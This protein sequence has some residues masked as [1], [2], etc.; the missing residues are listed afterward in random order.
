[1]LKSIKN[2]SICAAVFII[3]C[4][5]LLFWVMIKSQSILVTIQ[6]VTEP[7]ETS[8]SLRG[9]MHADVWYNAYDIVDSGAWRYDAEEGTYSSKNDEIL[10]LKVPVCSQFALVFNAGPNEGVVQIKVGNNVYLCDLYQETE[11]EYGYQ[12][13]LPGMEDQFITINII[14]ALICVMI[15][16]VCICITAIYEKNKDKV[17]L[18][19]VEIAYIVA[20]IPI[21]ALLLYF[22]SLSSTPR[23]PESASFWGYDGA[24][25]NLIG[26]SWI[27]GLVP[28]KDI[29]EHKGPIAFFVFMIGNLISEHW[30]IYFL[31]CICL[32]I[33][34]IYSYKIGKLFS[35]VWGGILASL[36]SAIYFIAVID[37]GGLLEEFNLPL[38]MISCYL[39]MKYA[40]SS[41]KQIKHPWKYAVIYGA[42]F[43]VSLGLRVTNAIAIC[44]FVLCI[45]IF[46]LYKREYTNLLHNIAAFLLGFAIIALPFIIYFAYHGALY[47]ML[48]GTILFNLDYVKSTMLHSKEEIKQILIYLTPVIVSCM[49]AIGK[50]EVLRYTILLGGILS[51]YFMASSYV[52]PHYYIVLTIFAPIAIGLS[53]GTDTKRIKDINRYTISY[54]I[55]VIAIVL[56]V[57]S[58]SYENGVGKYQWI[59]RLSVYN[60]EMQ[61][62]NDIR[63]Q[64][65]IIPVEDRDKV[66]GYNIKANWYLING[67]Y[68]CY[69]YYGANDYLHD[70]SEQ[71]RIETQEYYSSLDAQWIVVQDDIE[72]EKIKGIIEKNYELQST[73]NI[74]NGNYLV[75]L[76]KKIE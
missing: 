3:L 52:Y 48:Y 15:A 14:T 45:T 23:I 18:K 38:L 4:S 58:K 76:Y 71:V 19:V 64:A 2:A 13:S 21:A 46:L 51:A 30:G 37:E 26:K 75:S 73:I 70:I 8:I 29:F 31:Q 7:V 22:L 24:V 54:C 12:Y 60:D 40:I 74:T 61:D 56:V 11:S 50:K 59:T 36:G 67:I 62:I 35:S 65:S 1:M 33:S 39:V 28:Y 34:L 32:S 25:Y 9:G 16:V 43:G 53:I 68:P 55:V 27:E 72:D 41:C 47:D 42:T 6:K 66:I 69:K 49:F 5:G 57:F 63:Q 20:L 44:A 17:N 10:T